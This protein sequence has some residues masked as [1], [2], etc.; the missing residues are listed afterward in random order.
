MY[1]VK[2]KLR[3]L[4]YAKI[5]ITT[6]WANAQPDGR[7]AEYRWRPVLNATV[8]LAPTARLPYSNAANRRAQDL[9]DAK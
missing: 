2:Q 1:N 9:E 4:R 8:W 6:M 5:Y 7:P 3:H